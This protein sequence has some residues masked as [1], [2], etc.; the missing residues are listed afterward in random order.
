MDVHTL[1]I[2]LPSWLCLLLQQIIYVFYK[3]FHFSFWLRF[4]L[5]LCTLIRLNVCLRT[6][7]ASLKI[8][9]W[10][11]IHLS[12]WLLSW[13]LLSICGICI[14]ILCIVLK[15]TLRDHYIFWNCSLALIFCFFLHMLVQKWIKV[16]STNFLSSLHQEVFIIFDKQKNLLAM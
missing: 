13:S 14:W 6:L 1:W 10:L 4:R 7:N 2:S 15:K 3:I 16:C 11:K 5:F 8:C 9:Q 12:W